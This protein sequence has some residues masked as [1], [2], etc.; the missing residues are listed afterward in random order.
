MA[1]ETPEIVQSQ[2]IS[3]VARV[4]LI[5]WFATAVSTTPTP[6]MSRMIT[7]EL[8]SEIFASMAFMM[9]IDL[10]ESM[11]PTIGNIRMPCQIEVTG[12]DISI[13]ASLCWVMISPVIFMNS[14]M[15]MAVSRCISF[16][17]LTVAAANSSAESPRSR[18]ASTR[19]PCMTFIAGR[20]A[21]GGNP[22][23]AWVSPIV[24]R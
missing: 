16:V 4:I 6:L 21:W 7:F 1:G 18:S 20:Y 24:R 22:M 8:V 17:M 14:S 10:F 23:R 5:R 19:M 15:T 3:F 13:S 12:V 11:M 2:P 9:S